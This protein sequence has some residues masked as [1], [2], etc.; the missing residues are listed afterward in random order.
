MRCFK[1]DGNG[2]VKWDFDRTKAKWFVG[3]EEV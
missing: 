2:K 1:M 3:F